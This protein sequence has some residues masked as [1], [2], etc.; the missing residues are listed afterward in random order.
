M[1]ASFGRICAAMSKNCDATME[2]K[3]IGS[4]QMRETLRFGNH[5]STEQYN[6]LDG[7]MRAKVPLVGTYYFRVKFDEE[8]Q[9][10]S[11]KGEVSGGTMFIEKRIVEEIK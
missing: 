2:M 6:V 7:K 4:H 8:N 1:K 5:K 3:Q 9:A 11:F 10:L